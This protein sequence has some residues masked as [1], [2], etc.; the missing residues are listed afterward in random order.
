M[1][2]KS[3][4]QKRQYNDATMKGYRK[5]LIE[6]CGFPK[7]LM[8]ELTLRQIYFISVTF[9]NKQTFFEAQMR[10]LAKQKCTF[11]GK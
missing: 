9:Q 11:F 10:D 6:K 5:Y 7:G 4:S 8:K 1:A 2:K 3:W